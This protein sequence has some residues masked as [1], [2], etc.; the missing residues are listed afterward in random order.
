MEN[1]ESRLEFERNIHQ[2]QIETLGNK[3]TN[4]IKDILKLNI[5][6]IRDIIEDTPDKIKYKIE[7]RLEMIE[8]SLN[9]YD[10]RN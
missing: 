4:E 7:R 3:I 6:G 10:W 9:K 1:L 8:N 5:L 2:H